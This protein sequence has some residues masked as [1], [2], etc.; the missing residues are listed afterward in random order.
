MTD[1]SAAVRREA[2]AWGV[3]AAGRAASAAVSRRIQ[4]RVMAAEMAAAKMG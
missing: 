3:L 4:R 2:M 1:Q